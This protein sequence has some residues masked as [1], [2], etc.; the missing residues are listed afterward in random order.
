MT[1][2]L[3]SAAL[4]LGVAGLT[5][6]LATAGVVLLGP[7]GWGGFALG[8][9]VSYA[10]AILSFLGAVHWGLALRAAAAEAWATGRRLAFGVVPALIG[11]AALLV[12]DAIGLAVLIAAFLAVW[13]AEEIAGRQ[14]LVPLGYLWLRRGLTLVAVVAMSAVWTSLF[15]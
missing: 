10:A 1:S 5:P 6:F 4:W 14:G 2:S 9:H 3:P 7:E 12:P 15:A 13:A 8:V 11:W